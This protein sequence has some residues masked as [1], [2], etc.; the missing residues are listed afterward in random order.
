MFGKLA[1]E[2]TRGTFLGP[3]GWAGGACAAS[4]APE[5]FPR[6]IS[7]DPA[8]VFS[9]GTHEAHRGRRLASSSARG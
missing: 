7:R 6:A 1:R 3:A 2:L 4:A 5:A 9:V 8:A